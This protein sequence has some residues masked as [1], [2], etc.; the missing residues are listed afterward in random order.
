MC[1]KLQEIKHLTPLFF[2]VKVCGMGSDIL[3]RVMVRLSNLNSSSARNTK[4]PRQIDYLTPSSSFSSFSLCLRKE[5]MFNFFNK[6]VDYG[7]QKST[8]L[9]YNVRLQMINKK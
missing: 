4:H 6:K 3:F 8:F 5:R 2:L 1:D 7:L 9:K